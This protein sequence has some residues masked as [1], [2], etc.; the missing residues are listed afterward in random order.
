[1]ILLAAF[2]GIGPA[3]QG[4]VENPAS[5]APQ[6]ARVAVSPSRFELEIGSAPVREALRVFNFG[7]EPVEARV[8]VATWFLD[9]ENQVQLVEPDEQSLETWMIF[10]PLHFTVGPGESQVVRFSIQPRVEPEP[11]EHRAMIYLDQVPP[12]AQPGKVRVR[13]RFGV[14]VYAYAGEVTRRGEL[15]ALTVSPETN[16][17]VAVV[18]VASRG[19]AHVRLDGS[20][21]VWPA[22]KG[23]GSEDPLD[24]GSLPGAPIL[25]GTTR[26]LRLTTSRSLTPGDYRLTIEGTL[27]GKPIAR[28]IRF[29]VPP[30]QSEDADLAEAK[31]EPES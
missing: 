18:T 27:A 8:S 4:E 26:D 23:R 7:S 16:P 19:N 1:L 25:P 6:P 12:P 14:A 2:P 11:G 5:E 17:P 10:N 13:F 30:T 22:Q 20:W 24:T 29:T 9:D 15:T 31:P 3:A 28:E 21:A